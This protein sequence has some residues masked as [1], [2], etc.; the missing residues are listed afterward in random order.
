MEYL[1]STPEVTHLPAEPASPKHI[2]I[3]HFANCKCGDWHTVPQCE[4][5]IDSW[6]LQ[7][8]NAIILAMSNVHGYVACHVFRT[9]MHPA[10]RSGTF[11]E[12]M[13]WRWC[14]VDEARI[15]F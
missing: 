11:S 15:D 4:H 14:A 12:L 7:K 3:R 8:A 13:P 5:R 6:R 10:F 9:R 1:L 2:W